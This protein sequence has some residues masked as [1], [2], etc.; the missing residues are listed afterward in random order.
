MNHFLIGND[1]DV[2]LCR[3]SIWNQ[4]AELADTLGHLR[5]DLVRNFLAGRLEGIISA[6]I[7]SEITY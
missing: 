3:K 7:E 6:N 2:W 4:S 5:V 1:A